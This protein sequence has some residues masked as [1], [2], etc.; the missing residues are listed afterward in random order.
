MGGPVCK[1]IIDNGYALIRMFNCMA[2]SLLLA[3]AAK[4]G[5][6]YVDPKLQE[7]FLT[8]SEAL[9]KTC[10]EIQATTGY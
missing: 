1:I 2:T 5:A 6:V 4:G 8:Q 10:A 3:S 9:A 7:L